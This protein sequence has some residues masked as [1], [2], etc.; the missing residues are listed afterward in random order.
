[1]SEPYHLVIKAQA[2]RALEHQLS[3]STAFAVWEFIAGPLVQ[4]PQRV[5]KQLISPPFQGD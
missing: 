2:R 5:G 3:P 1:V 4:N